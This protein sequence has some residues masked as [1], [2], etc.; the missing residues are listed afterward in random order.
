MRARLSGRR[1]RVGEPQMT[2]ATSHTRTAFHWMCG[3]VVDEAAVR[4]KLRRARAMAA[5]IL[6]CSPRKRA[7]PLLKAL[8]MPSRLRPM[9]LQRT[10]GRI[11]EDGGHIGAMPDLLKPWSRPSVCRGRKN[12]TPWRKVCVICHPTAGDHANINRKAL[13]CTRESP[14][15]RARAR[16]RARAGSM[17][18]A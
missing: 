7:L 17:G 5:G 3:E 11:P 18:V 14:G 13:R 16:V 1:L 10:N 9:A 15:H 6:G 12:A 8:R 4:D 2:L